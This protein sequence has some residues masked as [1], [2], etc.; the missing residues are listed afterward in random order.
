MNRLL[1]AS[2]LASCAIAQ[3]NYRSWESYGGGPDSTHYSALDQVNRDNVQQLKVAWTYD[4]GDAREGS[5]IQSNPIVVGSTIYTTTP[6]MLV[7]ALNAASGKELWRHDPLNGNRAAHPNRGVSYWSDSKESRILL[8]VN[9]EI[10]SLDAATGRPD[11]AFGKKGRVDMRE[12]FD[13]PADSISLTVTTPPSIYQD[14]LIVGSS[15]AEALPST[16]GDIRAYDVRTGKLRWKFHTI[17]HPGE[18]GYESWP[19]ETWKH[20][21]GANN[22]AGASVDVK[23]GLVFV[24]T[25]SAAFDFYGSDRHGDNLFANSLLCLDAATGKRK[26][27]FQLVRHDTWDLDLPQPPVLVTVKRDGKLV[28]AVAQAGKDGFVWVLNRETGESLFPFEERPVPASPVEGES[29]AK[30]QKFPLKPA[31][32]VRQHFSEKTVTNRTPEA[33]KAILE[34]LRSLETGPLF[35]PA[36]LKGTVFFPGLAGGAE[37]G[38]SAW[39]PET[40]LFYVNANEI[41]W[42]VRLIPSN[43]VR[44][45]SAMTSRLYRTQCAACHRSDK[46][47]A[48]PE[49]PALTGLAAKFTEESL[50]QVIRTGSGRMP[51]FSSLGEPAI[52]AI[53]K[54]LLDD[55]DREVALP[56]QKKEG[57]QLRY[58]VDGYNKFEDPDGYPANNPPWGTLSAI[59]LDTGEY[60]FRVPLGEYPELV[61]K[62]ITNTG[63]ENHGGGVVTAG[64]LFFIGATPHDKKFRAFDKRTGA[65]LWETTLPFACN[66]TPSVYEVNGKEYILLPAGGGRGRESGSQWIAYTLPDSP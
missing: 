18:A 39:D 26:W 7:V 23:R 44:A 41:P 3:T 60:A 30:T 62:G 56:Q 16:P 47:G 33:R 4:S 15:V 2:L 8:T 24:P 59:N 57:I 42:I 37:W 12:A 20:S 66:A 21:G 5:Q 29:L 9:H 49:Y 10:V 58:S 40:N 55:V 38:G 17:P 11:P 46:K 48:P 63:S 51:G 52:A 1:L 50:A 32:F 53:A 14:L 36:S 6:S 28:D 54:Y 45:R 65:L 43:E 61:A 22:W 34:Q 35:T 25:G 13:R 19:A 31:P 64:G 27:H